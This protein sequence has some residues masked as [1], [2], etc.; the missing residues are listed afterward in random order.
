MIRALVLCAL[1]LS[2]CA[3]VTPVDPVEDGTVVCDITVSFGSYAMG[4]DH[5]L[6]TRIQALLAADQG[7]DDTEERP[8]GREG[9]SNLCIQASSPVDADHLFNQI[10]AMIPETSDR[11]PTTVTHRDGRSD[12]SGPP[13]EWN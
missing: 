6:K 5:E 1:V 3:P 7:V 9:E 4:V 13:P 12:A 2:A 10:A 8:W 11:A